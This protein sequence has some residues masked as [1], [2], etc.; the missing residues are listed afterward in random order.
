MAV[1]GYTDTTFQHYLHSVLGREELG[2]V[3]G[4]TVD[5]NKYLNAVEETLL[6][7][8]T[9]DIT[10]LTSSADLR[11]LRAVGRVELW[12][13]VMFATAGD[14]DV[15]LQDGSDYKRSQLHNQAKAMHEAA[16]KEAEQLGADVG[17]N[18]DTVHAVGMTKVIYA[19]DVYRYES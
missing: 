4:W 13:S 1:S 15:K 5:D 7:L 3:L 6:I 18:L 10:G 9:T 17:A 19:Q 8:D 14:Y 16:V 11:K 2:T 12:K